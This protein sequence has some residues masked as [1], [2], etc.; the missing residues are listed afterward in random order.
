[1]QGAVAERWTPVPDAPED[2]ERRSPGRTRADDAM[3]RY[4]D[5]EEAA[6]GL[7]YDALAPRLWRYALRRTRSRSAAEDVVQQTFLQL[8]ASRDRFARG[9][10]VLPWA[11][12]IARR[13]VLDA[14]RR[15]VREPLQAGDDDGLEAPSPAPRADD[16]LVLAEQDRAAR[17]DLER[18]PPAMREPFQ[19]VK[20]DGLSV[21]EAAEVLGITRGMVKIRTHRARLRL[22]RIALARRAR[23]GS[24]RGGEPDATPLRA[25]APRT[26]GGTP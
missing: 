10:A 18:L 24:F 13:L 15:E 6:F 3:D 21:A 26:Q 5:G 14:S 2:N 1:M 25:P 11:Y 19:L 8:H 23:D 12:A 4:A 17:R 7:L 20:L 16:A 22:E 9:A